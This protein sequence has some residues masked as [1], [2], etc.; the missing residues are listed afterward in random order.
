[1]YTSKTSGWGAI[2]EQVEGRAC[3]HTYLEG[4]VE[5]GF[6]FAAEVRGGGRKSG[7]VNGAWKGLWKLRASSSTVNVRGSTTCTPPA[8]VAAAG[9]CGVDA[10]ARLVVCMMANR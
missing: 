3:E 8:M 6:G 4:V 5:G 10:E 2:T 7:K 1:M 9:G